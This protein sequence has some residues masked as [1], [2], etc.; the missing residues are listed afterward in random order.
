MWCANTQ[1][2][3]IRPLKRRKSCHLPHHGWNLRIL[4][5][6]KCQRMTN[7]IWSHLYVES[8]KAKVTETENRLVLPE[9]GERGVMGEGGHKV[10]TFSY[11]IN[12]F[13]DVMY[14]TV[15][16]VICLLP[17]SPALPHA[18]ASGH[19]WT[20]TRNV[21]ELNGDVTQVWNIHWLS[22]TWCKRKEYKISS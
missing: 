14:V 7:T 5:Y 21:T 3:A 17:S 19:M 10:Q 2:N 16:T 4:C 22:K 9:L 12:Q 15:S 8:K 13:W 11:K 6:V 20:V 1:W 18:V